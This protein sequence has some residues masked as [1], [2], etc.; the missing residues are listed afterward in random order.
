[1]MAHVNN[2]AT[3]SML[4]EEDVHMSKD[5]EFDYCAGSLINLSGA[6]AEVMKICV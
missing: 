6:K 3:D 4:G 5:Y 1:M 2:F